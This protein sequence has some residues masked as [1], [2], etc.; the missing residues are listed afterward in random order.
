MQ[1]SQRPGELFE[2]LWLL[3]RCYPV[4]SAY[5]IQPTLS[6]DA[7]VEYAERLMRLATIRDGRT[8]RWSDPARRVA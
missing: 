5:D 3:R 1:S 4:R 6:V 8:G 2:R 7:A